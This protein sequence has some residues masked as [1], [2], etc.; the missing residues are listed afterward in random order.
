MFKYIDI[1]IFT[2]RNYEIIQISSHLYLKMSGFPYV[3]TH[4]F[5]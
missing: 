2:E 1:Y 3:G 5:Y 4:K